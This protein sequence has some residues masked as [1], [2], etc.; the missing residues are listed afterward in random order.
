MAWK[1]PFLSL[2]ELR[3]ARNKDLE[4]DMDAVRQ[5]IVQAPLTV[6]RYMKTEEERK[7]KFAAED[8][9]VAF[10]K[11][12]Q[13]MQR[14]KFGQD[15][16]D[17]EI[18]RAREALTKHVAGGLLGDGPDTTPEMEDDLI[19]RT[20]RESPALGAIADDQEVRGEIAKQRQALLDSQ[21]NRD[22]KKLMATASLTNSLQGPARVKNQQ[23]ALDL[24][25]EK[26]KF[27]EF[28]A[29]NRNLPAK[30]AEVF[31][32]ENETLGKII[33][34]RENLAANNVQ[35]GI[36]TGVESQIRKFVHMERTDQAAVRHEVD[37][38]FKAMANDTGGLSLTASEQA[39]VRQLLPTMYDQGEIWEVILQSLEKASK[40]RIAEE[41]RLLSAQPGFQY[42]QG[43]EDGEMPAF[44]APGD[45]EQP[46][47]PS[48]S[49]GPPPRAKSQKAPPVASSLPPPPP[50]KLRVKRKA[51]GKVGFLPEAQARAAIAAGKAEE[52]R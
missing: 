14:T 46:E 21:A 8:Q 28:M 51:D 44:Q 19:V 25:A 24:R 47:Q 48:S 45:D 27:D 34:L 7:R 4:E 16:E 39:I 5:Q 49:V 50:G 33:S 32:K 29:L 11:E 22:Y 6:D 17:R 38:L 30:S 23:R 41:K 20:A 15:T 43:W 31:R 42:V 35:P 1:S 52:V 36:M 10:D 9:K 18:A 40:R 37:M 12:D 13:E 2:D 3:I 26:Q